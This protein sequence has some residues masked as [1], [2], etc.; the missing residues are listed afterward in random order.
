[1]TRWSLRPTGPTQNSACWVHTCSRGMHVPIQ[2]GCWFCS[3]AVGSLAL[4]SR[5]GCSTI[6]F[7]PQLSDS[8]FQCQCCCAGGCTNVESSWFSN[9]EGQTG[10]TQQTFPSGAR[11]PKAPQTRCVACEIACHELHTNCCSLQLNMLA[12]CLSRKMWVADSTTLS[13]STTV[14]PI[15]PADASAL[16]QEKSFPGG[17]GCGKKANYRANLPPSPAY[18]ERMKQSGPTRSKM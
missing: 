4:S 10:P 6:V 11:L 2:L 13:Y 17:E 1:M 3:F 8:S 16:W 7:E 12:Q 18:W 14:Y 9:A 5:T 15:A